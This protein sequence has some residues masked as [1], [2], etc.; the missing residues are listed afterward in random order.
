[1]TRIPYGE[2]SPLCVTRLMFIHVI[3][4]QIAQTDAQMNR[5]AAAAAYSICLSVSV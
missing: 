1:M 2:K 5:T 4:A 3:G